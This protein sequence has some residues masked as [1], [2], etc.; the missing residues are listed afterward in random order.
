MYLGIL[1]AM[2]LWGFINWWVN[3]E[4]VTPLGKIYAQVSALICTIGLFG[5]IGWII[6][7]SA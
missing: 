1:I 5:A 3:A 6:E 4:A 7:V 2:F